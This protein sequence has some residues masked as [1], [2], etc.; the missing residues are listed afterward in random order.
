MDDGT[1]TMSWT[2]GR[3]YLTSVERMKRA[4]G[5]PLGFSVVS[6]VPISRLAGHARR[7]ELG[8][9]AFGALL[10][11]F[12]GTVAWVGIARSTRRLRSM[13]LLLEERVSQRTAEL[14]AAEG[15][16]QG[17]FENVP[18]GLYQCDPEGRFLRVNPM[19][20]LTLGYESPGGAHREPGFAPSRGGTASRAP[21]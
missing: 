15:S 9:L 3:D 1:V 18:L 19:L 12:A 8:G 2:D 6:G 5:T 14:A 4:N 16:F 17:I 21:A 11:L 20:A 7:A 13:N 10:G